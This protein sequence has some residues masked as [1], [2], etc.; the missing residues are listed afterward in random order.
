M[1]ADSLYC[2]Q[3][4]RQAAWR[5]GRGRIRRERA[6]RPMRFAYA[7][8]PYPEMA[9]RYYQHHR[10]FAGEVDHGR[11]VEQ[12]ATGGYDG[13]ALSTSAAALRDVLALCP[14]DVRVAAWVRGERPTRSYGP[15]NA[16]EPV[17]YRG[18]RPNPSPSIDTRRID[19]LVHR[20][21]ARTTDPHRIIGAKPAE[22][23]WWLFELLGMRPGDELADLFPGSGGVS[24]AWALV[25]QDHHDGSSI[26]TNVTIRSNGARIIST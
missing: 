14:D 19:A 26:G 12:L 20:A 6:D 2:K 10:D 9:R 1:R 11:L 5:F 7:D 22:F 15:L 16:W 18:G 8:P 23:C 17:I 24:R 21:R 3:G 25:A 13:W 4:C